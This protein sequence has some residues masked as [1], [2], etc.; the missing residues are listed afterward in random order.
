VDWFRATVER[1]GRAMATIP[2]RFMRWRTSG[3]PVDSY[4]VGDSW[5][6]VRAP[7]QTNVPWELY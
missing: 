7:N 5:R 3:D 4:S 6:A 1:R 2:G